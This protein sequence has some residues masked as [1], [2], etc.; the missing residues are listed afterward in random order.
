MGKK[1]LAF[2]ILA[3]IAFS[4]IV[5]V[6]VV[7]ASEYSDCIANCK[8]AKPG[9]CATLCSEISPD[10]SSGG[11]ASAVKK[12]LTSLSKWI[13]SP[14]FDIFINPSDTSA[15]GEIVKVLVLLLILIFVYSALSYMEFPH[16]AGLRFLVAIILGVLVTVL[17]TTEEMLTAL[18]SYKAAGLSIMIFLPIMIL[19]FFSF[20]VAVRGGTFFGVFSQKVMWLV[21]SIYLFV[22]TAGLLMLKYIG[23]PTPAWTNFFTFLLGDKFKDAATM[24]SIILLVMVSVSIFVFFMFVLNNKWFIRWLEGEKLDS[25]L[26]R[27]RDDIDRSQRL[28]KVEAESTRKADKDR[29]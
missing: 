18:L 29:K 3:L 9:A 11:V 14:Y 23:T 19:A 20:M 13:D 8:E 22:T 16:N 7:S 4:F 6:G 28:R 10:K 2:L 21:Y 27:M 24:D 26:T 1:G 12:P 17:I 25:D 5:G 15:L